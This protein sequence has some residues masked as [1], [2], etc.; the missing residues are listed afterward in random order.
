MSTSCTVT[1]AALGLVHRNA[2][3]GAAHLYIQPYT[4]EQVKSLLE[5]GDGDPKK[6]AIHIFVAKKDDANITAE[7]AAQW[8]HEHKFTPYRIFQKDDADATPDKFTEF[9]NNVVKKAQLTAA[10]EDQ[11]WVMRSCLAARTHGT[12]GDVLTAMAHG[13]RRYQEISS[14]HVTPP[15]NTEGWQ[16]A[17]TNYNDSK[18]GSGQ[19]VNFVY[20]DGQEKLPRDAHVLV[21]KHKNWTVAIKTEAATLASEHAVPVIVYEPAEVTEA[22][23]THLIQDGIDGMNL[24]AAYPRTAYT[25]RHDLDRAVTNVTNIINKL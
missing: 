3:S 15:T 16:Q 9:V 12:P 1:D 6:H 5:L 19:K 7:A 10:L 18:A 20:W 13:A 17:A 23:A 22:S 11:M 8:N 14:Y 4:A 24:N 21:V 2:D 25:Q